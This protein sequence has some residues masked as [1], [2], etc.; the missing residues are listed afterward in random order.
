MQAEKR[1]D[2]I[3]RASPPRTLNEHDKLDTLCLMVP[4]LHLS[5]INVTKL[6]VQQ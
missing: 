4:S 2:T 6:A 5:V 1:R 3:E